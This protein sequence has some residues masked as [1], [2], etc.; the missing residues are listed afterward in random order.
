MATESASHATII[1]EKITSLGGHP[2]INAALIE[3]T[4]QHGVQNILEESLR[5]ETE[6]LELYKQLVKLSGDDIA[7]EEL[8]REFVRNE[9]EHTDEVKKMLRSA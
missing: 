8:A 4:N 6:T 7:L 2:S 1:G 3:E 5:F 9:T